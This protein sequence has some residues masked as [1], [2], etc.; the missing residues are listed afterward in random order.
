MYWDSLGNFDDID[1]G[2]EFNFFN[3][4]N[5]PSVTRIFEFEDYV[6]GGP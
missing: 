5:L 6:I 1:E 4:V 2:Q 3:Y